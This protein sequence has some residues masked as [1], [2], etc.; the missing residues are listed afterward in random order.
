MLGDQTKKFDITVTFTA[1]VV[2]DEEGKETIL[3]V[4]EAISYTVGNDT[5]VHTIAAGAWKDGVATATVQLAHGDSVNFVNIPYGVTY[6]VSEA[7][8]ASEGY[9]AP[10]ITYTDE[11]NKEIDGQET[12]TVTVLNVKDGDIDTGISVDSIPYIAML[13]VVAVGGAGF[14][15]SKKRRSED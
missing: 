13:G 10:V 6:E 12:D 7:S 2:E 3:T 15:V 11:A 14:M 5:T 8:Y 4:K 1:P 9:N